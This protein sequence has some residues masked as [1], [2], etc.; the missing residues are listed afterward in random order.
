MLLL[1]TFGSN[2][3]H[4]W[5]MFAKLLYLILVS[6]FISLQF[7]DYSKSCMNICLHRWHIITEGNILLY[8]ELQCLKYILLLCMSSVHLKQQSF[9]SNCGTICASPGC[10]SA[11]TTKLKGYL[12]TRGQNVQKRAD[13]GAKRPWIS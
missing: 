1:P 13:K 4:Q 11:D 7:S 12:L 3:P 10:P 9:A 2:V 8:Q 6:C 5:L